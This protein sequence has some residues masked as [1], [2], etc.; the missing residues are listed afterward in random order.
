MKWRNAYGEKTDRE[1]ENTDQDQDE[2]REDVA[3]CVAER[4]LSIGGRH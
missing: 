2:E 1:G 4:G 3:E